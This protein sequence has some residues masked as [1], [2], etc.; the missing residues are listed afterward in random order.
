M[1]R[2]AA[3]TTGLEV[4]PSRVCLLSSDMTESPWATQSGWEAL[5]AAQHV[6]QVYP[7]GRSIRSV[8][9]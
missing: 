8:A 6:D 3:V 1:P 9:G 5:T 2:A 4:G 7:K